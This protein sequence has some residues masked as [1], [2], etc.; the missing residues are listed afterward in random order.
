G[1]GEGVGMLLVERLSDA[2]RNGHTVL[3]VVRGSAVNQD[4]ASNGLTAPNDLAQERVIRQALANAR[5]A[6][7]DVDAVEAHGTG[8]RLGDPIEAQALLATYGQDRPADRPLRLGS[9]KSNVGHTQ[10]AAGVAGVI[11]TVMAMRHGVLPRTL[12][13]EEPTPMV[14]WA[15]GGVALLTEPVAWPAGERVRR[16]AVS[17]FGVSGTN[18][19]IILEEAPPEPR[20][21]ERP[22]GAD[23]AVVPWVLSARSAAG[24][25]AQAARLRDWVAEHPDARPADVAWSLASGRAVLQHRAVLVGREPVGLAAGLS[26]VAEGN[27][28]PLDGVGVVSGAVPRGATR[29]AVL[30]TG[31]GAR[32]RGIGRELYDAFPVFAAALDEVCAAFEGALPF[33]VRDVVLGAPDTGAGPEDPEDTGIAQPALFAF[34]VALYRLWTSWGQRPDHVAG[35]S[36]GEIVAAHVAQ[37]L[38]LDDAVALVAA[39]ARLMSSL[40]DGGAMLAVGASEAA[41]AEV[42]AGLPGGAGLAA[43]N[44]PMSV[45]VSGTAEA[46]EQVRAACAD[47]GWRCSRLRVSHAFHSELMEP[48]L[49]KFANV[50]GGLRFRPPVIPLA[51]NVTGTIVPPDRLCEPGYWVEHLRRTV[52]FAE[53]IGALRAA[54]VTTFVELGPEAA[55][56]PLVTECLAAEE[57][58]RT[59]AAVPALRR[60]RDAVACVLEA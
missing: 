21:G 2:H 42:L 32:A 1:W 20:D 38:S 22:A 10:A 26:A 58:D 23:P 48:V 5:L 37:V 52:R 43:V 8:T 19:H 55:L 11:K 56:T 16:A 28:T 39:R 24:L 40:P 18:A 53:G 4:G 54:G 49:E 6:P 7:A 29:T 31:Q 41:V 36:L 33:S 57:A 12:H 35:H 45:V 30:F 60:D 9:V 59:V 3:A 17:S 13:A 51:S 14:D 25:R 34:E 50:V 47:R 46:V 15:A 27:A 44:G